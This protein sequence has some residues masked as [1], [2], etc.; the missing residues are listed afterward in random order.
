MNR[1]LLV[2]LPLLCALALL[3]ACPQPEPEPEPEPNPAEQDWSGDLRSAALSFDLDSMTATA[4]ISIETDALAAS[5]EAGS[6]D[7][8]AVRAGEVDLEFDKDDGRLDIGLPDHD[9][10]VDVIIEYDFEVGDRFEGLMDQ[11]T[12]LTWPYHC[13]NLFPCRPH[14]SD[15]L[16]FDLS[17]TG[18]PAGQT[19]VTGAIGPG[20][21]PAY[22]LAWATGEY[23]ELELGTTSAGTALSTWYLPGGDVNAQTGTA[24][25][26]AVFD[27]LEQ[28]LGP[29][30]F[31]DHAGSVEV[32]W[33]AGAY[34]GMEHHPIWHVSGPAMADLAV[35]SH[36]AAHGWF[37]GGI[38]LDCWED[39]VL[40][41][42]TASYLTA[43]AIGQVLGPAAEEAVWDGYEGRLTTVFVHGDYVVLPDSCGEVDVIDDGLFGDAV[44]MKGAWFWRQ[45]AEQVGA[46]ALDEAFAGFFASH[47]GGSARMTELVAYV[48]AE[49]G[50]DLSALVQGWLRS[51]GDPR[52]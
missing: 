39:L 51:T 42:G 1:S 16:T 7:V 27:W 17:V 37:G 45:T 32:D 21:A 49:T 28:T 14:P 31:G 15:G 38:R 13:G 18:A 26:V 23:T 35:H 29:Y 34:G 6:L 24:D 20:E 46:E 25:L 10:L 52:Q 3:C 4:T 36:E 30:P 41:E 48:E 9:G 22:Q 2:A 5:L 19:T 43:R 47:V 33:G 8:E 44:Y 50:A 12:T 11:G 40:S